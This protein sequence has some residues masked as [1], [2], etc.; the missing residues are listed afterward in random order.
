MLLLH[1]FLML[2]INTIPMK[3]IKFFYNLIPLELAHYLRAYT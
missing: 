3:I 2:K 1:N